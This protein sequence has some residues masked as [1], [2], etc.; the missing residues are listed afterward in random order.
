[1][2][3]S[4]R[5][6]GFVKAINFTL[7][8]ETGKDK[9]GQLRAD[10][11]LV[12]DAGGVTKYGI[13]D[14]G[15]GVVDGKYDGILIKDLTVDQ[16]ISIYKLRYWD[17]Y[18]TLRPTSANLDALP[19]ALAVAVFDSGVNCGPNRGITWLS[20]ALQQKNPTK[21]VI[22]QRVA[23]YTDKASRNPSYPLKGMLNRTN[24][25]RK[26]CDILE[27]D[28]QQ[29]FNVLETILGRKI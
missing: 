27:R 15:D 13:S 1:M 22:D 28:D 11:G 25:L 26:Y 12:V 18:L 7:P 24:D 5:P 19:T 20:T 3:G 21:S 8:W 6:N 23:F 16:A 2:A 14:R 10:G 29:S 9:N 4:A 17:I